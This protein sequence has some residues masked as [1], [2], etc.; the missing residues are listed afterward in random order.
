[1]LLIPPVGK[2][3]GNLTVGNARAKNNQ[4]SAPGLICIY[5]RQVAPGKAAITGAM[6]AAI[7]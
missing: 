5:I 6:K 7:L 3:G 2:W 1:M 4:F